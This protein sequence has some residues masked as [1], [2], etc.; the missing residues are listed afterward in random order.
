M[1]CINY[2]NSSKLI[3][4][5]WSTGM[6]LS[7]THNTL[8]EPFD[9]VPIFIQIDTMDTWYASGM[10]SK[11]RSKQEKTNKFRPKTGFLVF[12]LSDINFPLWA[13]STKIV[14]TKS[15]W[16]QWSDTIR[17]AR[18]DKIICIYIIAFC[19]HNYLSNYFSWWTK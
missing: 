1:T 16:N 18:M 12:K 13:T 19:V 7:V 15:E 10:H 2:L 3:S 14:C 8:S 6:Y 9:V 4:C 17:F 5:K 11:I